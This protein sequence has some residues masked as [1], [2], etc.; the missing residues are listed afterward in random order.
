[1]SKNTRIL[2]SSLWQRPFCKPNPDKPAL[3]IPLTA[4]TL[5]FIVT[6]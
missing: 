4:P 2:L 3:Q 6:L 1:L 5:F